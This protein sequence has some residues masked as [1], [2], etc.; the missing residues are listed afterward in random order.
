VIFIAILAIDL[1][2]FYAS[3]EC[4]LRNL[5]PFETALVVADESRGKGS[6]VL[7]VTPYLKKRN[8][9]SRLRIFEL[10]QDIK[11]E[12]AKP[13]M[14]KY[15]DYSGMIYEVY[16]EFVS[17]DDIHV[18]SIDEAFIDVTS[19]LRHAKKTAFQMAQ[20]IVK[21][22]FE[23]T[24]ITATCG[25]GTNMFLAKV[26]LDLLAK[27]SPEGIV[28]IDQDIFI[29]EIRKRPVEDFW[30]IGSRM[31]IRLNQMGI[32]T[33]EDVSKTNPALL[34]KEFGVIGLEIYEHSYGINDSHISEIKNYKPRNKSI[35]NGQVLPGEYNF[36]EAALIIRE[37]VDVVIMDL[38]A[39]RSF[40]KT[41]SLSIMYSD[42]VS[43]SGFSRQTTLEYP[44]D[45]QKEIQQTFKNLYN[46]F[47][48]DYPI[49]RIAVRV[50]NL[51]SRDVIQL[52][53]FQ[54]E[55]KEAKERSL[56]ETL[57]KLKKRYGRD[58]INKAES[59]EPK[60]MQRI[61]NKQIGGH[62]E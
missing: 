48:E 24:K 46:Q 27:K 40:C 37:M 26:A 5:D 1:K 28:E 52:S 33:M 13:Q 11:I 2:S 17:K 42:K 6:I 59:S 50:A 51:S 22:V 55:Q 38:I 32:Y 15:I 36:K 14:Q 54:D 45:S 21:R 35:G 61:R 9:P 18:Y 43:A 34:E 23:K 44:T 12:F 10:P 8:V 47:V 60:A 16:L 58:I 7:A 39:L 41:I 62:N 3:V 25:I 19:Y 57:L 29:S 31:Q 53:L 56:T 20:T 30:G 49:R 4:A